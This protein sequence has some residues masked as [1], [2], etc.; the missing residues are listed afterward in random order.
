MG[1]PQTPSKHV[2][3]GAGFACAGV[4]PTPGQRCD[5]SLREYHTNLSGILVHWFFWVGRML[6]WTQTNTLALLLYLSQSVII[7]SIPKQKV[8]N[9]LLSICG[10]PAIV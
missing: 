10:S 4:R 6:Q 1:W 8:D 2:R 9:I 7:E 3:A 5:K